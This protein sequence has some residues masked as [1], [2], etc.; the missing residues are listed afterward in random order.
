[1]N[2]QLY[3][4]LVQYLD[5]L[6]FPAG[7]DEMEKKKIK[8]ISVQFV[9]KNNLLF[10]NI[11]GELKRVIKEDQVESVL[12]NLHQ[13]LNAAHLGI[14][15]VF[16]KVRERYFWPQIFEDVRKYVNSCDTYQ[17]RGSQERREALIP[18]KVEGPFSRIGIDIKGSLP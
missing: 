6:T 7:L 2:E 9:I 13:D 4:N 3:E 5:M 12:Y 16:E 17:R 15:A 11:K 14:D 1:M 18:L 8:K 10:K